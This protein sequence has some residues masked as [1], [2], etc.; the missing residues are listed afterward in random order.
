MAE[1]YKPGPIERAVLAEIER[2]ERPPQRIVAKVG[3]AGDGMATVL[4]NMVLDTVDDAMARLVE[5]DD[6]AG[7]GQA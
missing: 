4:A 5:A 2:A 6:K 3:G 1:E 7:E